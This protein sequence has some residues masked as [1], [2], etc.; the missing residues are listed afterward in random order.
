VIFDVYFLS[1]KG[2]DPVEALR[3]GPKRGE[4]VIT[5]RWPGGLRNDLMALLLEPGTRNELA[6]ALLFPSVI[7]MNSLGMTIE[8]TTA[9]QFRNTA[10]AKIEYSKQR[11]LCKPPGAKAV[12]DT[13][14]L[15]KRSA[16][17][18]NAALASGFDPAHDDR[19][20]LPHPDGGPLM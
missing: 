9:H 13:E 14:K 12:L 17:R 4:L 6:P 2:A 18:L 3:A 10:K 8:G 19:L 5:K 1:G 15:L 16:A 7:A 20:E 11:W